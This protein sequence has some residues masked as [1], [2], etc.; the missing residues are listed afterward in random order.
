VA[1]GLLEYSYTPGLTSYSGPLEIALSDP[2]F[3]LSWV[4]GPFRKVGNAGKHEANYWPFGSF[5]AFGVRS[6]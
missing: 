2:N 6:G 3:P 5:G 4:F 1:L